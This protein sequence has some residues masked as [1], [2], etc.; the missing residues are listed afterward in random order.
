MNIQTI[1]IDR[2]NA[3]AYNP[4]IDLQPGDPEY[5]KLRRSIESF[6]YVEPIVWNERTGNMVGGHQR[7]KIMVN[8]LGH[9]ELTVSVVDLDDQQ[10][11]LLNLALNK[12]SG[13]WDDEALARLLDEL[14]AGG[15]ELDLSGFDPAEADRLIADFTEPPDD[16]L[17][18]FNNK[19]L[20]VDEFD[21]SRFDCKCPRCGFLFDQEDAT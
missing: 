10:E 8:E 16:Q 5:E 9:T 12:V 13:G 19:E 2:I 20:D 4:R 6:G 11:R 7:Y 3:A 18:D 14:Q 15:A 21:E 17:G 1:P